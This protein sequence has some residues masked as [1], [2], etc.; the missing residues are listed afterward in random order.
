MKKKTNTGLIIESCLKAIGTQIPI[1]SGVASLY[2][3]WRNNIELENIHYL[4]EQ[5]ARSLQGIEEQ[6]DI[7]YLQSE[8]YVFTLHKTLLKAK[9]EIRESKKRLFADFL[10]K[11]CLAKN[12]INSDKMIFLEL[13]D[14]IDVEH[15]QLLQYLSQK[16]DS[17]KDGWALDSAISQDTG[18]SEQRIR[19]LMHYFISIGL[20]FDFDHLEIQ[21]TGHLVSENRYYISDLGVELLEFLKEEN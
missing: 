19:F 16:M 12:S 18:L 14:K 3:D 2:G 7:G 9:N 11:S 13:L 20:V 8:D 6:L 4:I 21:D 15:I 17:S 10:T 5:H 1:I